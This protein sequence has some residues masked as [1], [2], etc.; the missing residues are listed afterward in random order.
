MQG[1][2][3]PFTSAVRPSCVEINK[4]HFQNNPLRAHP[5]RPVHIGAHLDQ[6]LSDICTRRVSRRKKE[7]VAPRL[8]IGLKRDENHAAKGGLRGY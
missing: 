7:G 2:R 4:Q 3:K 8:I 5:I 1:F 6:V